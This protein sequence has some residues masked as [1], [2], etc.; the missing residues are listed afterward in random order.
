MTNFLKALLFL[1]FLVRLIYAE[2]VSKWLGFIR[3]SVGLF[4]L[5]S[6]V[7]SSLTQYLSFLKW[8]AL[9]KNGNFFDKNRAI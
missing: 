1:V 5:L 7:G 3:K 6:I 9:S 8:L 2:C 4:V